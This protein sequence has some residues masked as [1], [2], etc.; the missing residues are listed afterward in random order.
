MRLEDE[1]VKLDDEAKCIYL[2]ENY[3]SWMKTQVV[4]DLHVLMWMKHI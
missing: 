1:N 4:D 2:M 3:Y